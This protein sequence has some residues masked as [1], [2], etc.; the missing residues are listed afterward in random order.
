MS[1][2]QVG[3]HVCVMPS[4]EEGG[5]KSISIAGK[6]VELAMAGDSADVTLSDIDA[7]VLVAGTQAFQPIFSSLNSL[8]YQTSGGYL[9]F[10]L[11]AAPCEFEPTILH[12]CRSRAMLRLEFLVTCSFASRSL[13][14]SNHSFR[15]QRGCTVQAWQA[16][17]AIQD[18]HLAQDPCCVTQSFLFL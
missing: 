2:L 14:F 9:I 3:M 16:K 7:G 17:E 1:F 4:G 18:L 5:I 15:F 12:T 8:V 13:Q 10:L 11:D 6:K